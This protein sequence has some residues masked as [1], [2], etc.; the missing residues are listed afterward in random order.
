[1]SL[2]PSQK[3]RPALFGIVFSFLFFGAAPGW[4][5]GPS[6]VLILVNKDDPISSRVAAM[7][8]KARAI[9][10]ASPAGYAQCGASP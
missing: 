7:Y 4:T 8:Q 1:M 9:P 5:L 6:E 2:L 10:A 3:I